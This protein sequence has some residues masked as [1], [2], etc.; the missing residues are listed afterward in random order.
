MAGGQTSEE[1]ARVANSAN[2]HVPALDFEP[3]LD[4]LMTMLIQPRHIKLYYA[5]TDNN[6]EL[7]AF[8]LAELRSAFRR[9]A[10]TIPRYQGNDVS[11][12]LRT[13]ID[14]RIQAIDATIKTGNAKQ[15]AEEYALLT[16]AC[17]ACHTYLER[18]FL[19]I[20][21]PDA[22]AR[23]TYTDQRLRK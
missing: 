3:G 15:F 8:E 2:Q 20:K 5:G 9:T 16:T 13:F 12:T 19:V 10:Q 11:S 22:A 21:M 7:A 6:W 18:P 4:D 1:T 23:S 17:N 14:P